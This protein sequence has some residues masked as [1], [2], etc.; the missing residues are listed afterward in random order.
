M[1]DRDLEL[2]NEYY[3]DDNIADFRKIFRSLVIKAPDKLYEVCFMLKVTSLDIENIFASDVQ[4]FQSSNFQLWLL[5]YQKFCEKK[6]DVGVIQ[7][8]KNLMPLDIPVDVNNLKNIKMMEVARL[9]CFFENSINDD[10]ILRNFDHLDYN[11][12]TSNFPLKKFMHLIRPF[13]SQLD[14][15]NI[16]L[17]L[18]Y[19]NNTTP[20]VLRNDRIGFKEEKVIES[21][22][23]STYM[24]G[25]KYDKSGDI[26]LDEG[27]KITEKEKILIIDYVKKLGSTV[28]VRSFQEGLRRYNLGYLKDEKVLKLTRRENS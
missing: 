1:E 5:S 2:L 4:I 22:L 26:L 11:V 17:V 9:A 15:K 24:I 8:N 21:I 13:V 28:T 23:N 27:K 3:I 16:S 19:R 18:G 20:W 25:R 6:I 7:E 10:G 12:A 14:F